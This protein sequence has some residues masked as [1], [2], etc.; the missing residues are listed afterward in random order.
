MA[1]KDIGAKKILNKA[2]L[3]YY[4]SNKP[5]NVIETIAKGFIENGHQ[6][7]LLTQTSKGDLHRIFEKLGVYTDSYLIS[8]KTSLIYYLR[9][10]IYLISFCRKHN[11]TSVQS[12]LQQSNII[13]VFAQYFIKS[14]V[15]IYRHHLIELN[16][17]SRYF[18]RIINTLAKRIVVPSE[19]IRDKMIKDEHVYSEKIKLIPYVYDFSQY[20]NPSQENIISIRNNYKC[21]LLI[22]ICG[23]FV[24]LKRND[25][26]FYA[27][28]KLIDQSYDIKLMALDEGPGMEKLKEYVKENHLDNKVDFLG[29]RKNV[30]DYIAACDV[31]VNPSYAE[32]S[33]NSVKEAGSHS[34]NV[35]VCSHVGDFSEYIIHKKNGYLV[36]RDNPLAEII[37]CLKI[38][39]NDDSRHLI[40]QELKKTIYQK[41]HKSEII[42]QT[43]LQLLFD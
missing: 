1:S 37:D 43:H 32:A 3:I 12:H 13:A 33:N 24:S 4:P 35:I 20:P 15:V 27:L 22:L 2:I 38:I 31:L 42:I 10:L 41:F 23:R 34:K 40:G 25:L 16:K 7:F 39:Y 29:Y 8:K 21:K 17:I 14:R 30:M 11:I 19:V 5:S 28:K 26:V 9:H 18:D 36:N 6:V